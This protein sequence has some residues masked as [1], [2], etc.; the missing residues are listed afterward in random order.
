MVAS[1]FWFLHIW[2]LLSKLTQFIPPENLGLY[3]D[4]GLVEVKNAN[5]PKQDRIRK[6]IFECFK[7]EGLKVTVEINKIEADFLEATFN[8]QKEPGYKPFRKPN[9]TPSYINIHFNHPPIIKKNL[10]D[11]INRRLC[12]L[13]GNEEIFN[14]AK[15]PYEKSGYNQKLTYKINVSQ[16]NRL[17]RSRKILW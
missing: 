12:D 11:M 5:G 10:P 7:R 16:N 8:V 6:Q 1:F 15:E 17:N 13:S 3:R 14:E 4:D 9:D 2:Y